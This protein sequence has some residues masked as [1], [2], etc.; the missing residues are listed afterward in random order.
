M[1]KATK[2]DGKEKALSKCGYIDSL[3][4]AGGHTKAEILELTMKKFELPASKRKATA[5]TI[6]ARPSH[7]TSAGRKATWK[8]EPEEAKK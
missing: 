1:K 4:E 3:Y 5:S 2:K 7:M 8:P 6:N